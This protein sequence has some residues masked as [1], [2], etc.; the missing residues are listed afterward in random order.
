MI[1]QHVNNSRR[2]IE[3]AGNNITEQDDKEEG[4]RRAQGATE[5]I[6][7]PV[8]ATPTD[9]IDDSR[10][11]SYHH[12]L[13]GEECCLPEP[14]GIGAAAYRGTYSYINTICFRLSVF[15][16]PIVGYAHKRWH[17][18]GQVIKYALRARRVGRRRW[19][20]A[21]VSKKT[22][23]AGG[24]DTDGRLIFGRTPQGKDEDER[25]EITE[26]DRD[27][28]AWD[29]R[30]CRRQDVH[31]A[32]IG[33]LALR[34]GG[35]HP[36]AG[37]LRWLEESEYG[38]GDEDGADAPLGGDEWEPVEEANHEVQGH[39]QAIMEEWDRRW[40]SLRCQLP[41]K[42]I[43][44]SL[45][46]RAVYICQT[47]GSGTEI[48]QGRNA[49]E[50]AHEWACGKCQPRGRGNGDGVPEQQ[51]RVI[52][53]ADALDS[54][55]RVVI[56][57]A[58]ELERCDP[59]E[60]HRGGLDRGNEA[61]PV[62]EAVHAQ[63]LE[64]VRRGEGDGRFRCWGCGCTTDVVMNEWRICRCL[65]MY[66]AGCAEGPCHDCGARKIWG[67]AESDS[68]QGRDEDDGVNEEV[69]MVTYEVEHITF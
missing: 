35:P 48:P 5:D 38:S 44:G 29:F 22:R 56:S 52:S 43:R 62:G 37:V 11:F 68:E 8:V 17:K 67:V 66:C 19:P 57:I 58:D 41:P 61:D 54:Q 15:T 23:G 24:V 31:H 33:I 3:T 9:D 50:W 55:E 14:R 46:E 51:S 28:S 65:S 64:G 12:G 30:R 39:D 2:S 4:R 27:R 26:R 20:K 42:T 25:H 40:D 69:Q 53:I 21:R 18:T 10:N 49:W 36:A 34:G 7:F 63:E 60:W 59:T 13:L 16:L 45:N 47:C 1:P 32:G 6:G